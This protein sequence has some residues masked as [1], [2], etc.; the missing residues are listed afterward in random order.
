MS[1]MQRYKFEY[2]GNVYEV[3]APEGTSPDQLIAAVSQPQII[4]QA[5]ARTALQQVGDEM[6]WAEKGIVGIGRGMT[7]IGQ[8][9]K[10]LGLRAGGLVGAVSPEEIAAYD[11]QVNDEAALFEG[12]LGDSTAAGFGRFIGQT[13]VTLPVGGVGGSFIKGGAT[14][15]AQIGRAAAVGAGQGAFTGALNPVVGGGDFATEK[16]QQI[17]LGAA[18]GAPLGAAGQAVVRG[19]QGAVNAP[20]NVGNFLADTLSPQSPAQ[21][22]IA[23]DAAAARGDDAAV[24]A[25]I[26]ALQRAQERTAQNVGS[27]QS[28]LTG[29]NAQRRVGERVSQQSGITLSP[30]QASGSKTATMVENLARQSVFTRERMFLGDQKRARQMINAVRQFGR[31]LSQNETSPAVFA[32]R[33][34]STVRG[35]VTDLSKRRTEVAGGAY[36]AI[37][38]ATQGQPLVSTNNTLDEVAKL[39]SDFG[40]LSSADGKKISAWANDFFDRLKGDG[41]ITPDRAI[42]ELQAW[43]EAGRAGEGLFEGVTN[44]STAKTAANR[45][46]AAMMR[47]LDEAADASGGTVGESLRKANDLWRQ[48]SGEIDTLQASA[49]GRII[50]DDMV[51]ELSGTT[52]NTVSPEAVVRRLDGLAASE[53]GIVKDYLQKVNPQLWGEYQRLT[54]ER[55]MQAAR[56]SAPSMG[57]RPA[58]INPGAFVRQLEGSSGNQAVNSQARLRVLFDDNQQLA[59]ILEASRRMADSTGTNFSGTAPAQEALTMAQRL[60]QVGTQAAGGLANLAGLRVVATQSVPGAAR[61]PLRVREL[62]PNALGRIAAVNTAAAGAVAAQDPLEISVRGG[63]RVSVEEAGRDQREF[64]E[65]KRQRQQGQR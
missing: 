16:A 51:G 38:Q 6:N 17:G 13:A 5:P 15:L 53:L 25:L 12:G 30:A 43:T 8:G 21:I 56:A 4:S 50:G 28:V 7:E 33:L 41:S 34:Q 10:Q 55:A 26:P 49:L 29:S 37:T 52:F 61:V 35:M 31:Q 19:L 39:L 36:R 48:Y 64:L 23:I 47:D 20:A 32:E 62:S 65:W 60:S 18:L 40:D 54:V 3:E 63:T 27:I 58:A 59:S 1:A 11:A 2:G 57:G 44:R 9:A 45:L 22:Q 24:E 14:G 46:A 42:R